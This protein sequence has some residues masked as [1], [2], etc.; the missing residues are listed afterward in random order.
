M[1][2]PAFATKRFLDPPFSGRP[3]RFRS[4]LPHGPFPIGSSSAELRIIPSRNVHTNAL[5][6]AMEGAITRDGRR[7][8]YARARRQA[9]SPRSWRSYKGTYVRHGRVRPRIQGRIGGCNGYRAGYPVARHPGRSPPRARPVARGP[10]A[11]PH[12]T[13]ETAH[14]NPHRSS[15]ERLQVLD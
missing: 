6:R 5:F 4:R 15:S 7:P 11:T 9:S 3:R 8:P 1:M 10:C 14:R 13:A 12:A 2:G